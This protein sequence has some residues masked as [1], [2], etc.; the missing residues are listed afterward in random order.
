[1]EERK[2]FWD[3]YNLLVHG[4][5]MLAIILVIGNLPAPAPLTQLGMKMLGVFIGV[6]YGW[7]VA[8]LLWPTLIAMSA[9]AFTG[10]Y[11]ELSQFWVVSFGSET[12]VFL[13]FIFVFTGLLEETGLIKFLANLLISFKFLNN[14]PW[15]FSG[16]FMVA[17]FVCAI[18]NSFA[19]VLIFW[20]IVYI[21]AERFGFRP[22]D[23]WTTLMLMGVI[24]T[25]TLGGLTMPYQPAPL[26]LM[27]TYQ[28][29]TG[30]V[31]NFFQYVV[32]ALPIALSIVILYVL[33]CRFV[34]R[35]DLKGLKHIDVSFVDQD[36]LKLRTVQKIALIF[37]GVFIFFMLAPS[38]LP[39][40]WMF[41]QVLDKLGNSGCTIILLVLLCLI[42]VDGKPVLNFR[43][44]AASSINWEIIFAFAFIIPFASALTSDATGVKA[45][46][47]LILKP[48]LTALPPLGVVLVSLILAAI[49]TNFANNVVIEVIFTTL[50]VSLAPALGIPVVPAIMAVLIAANLS[51]A[52]PVASPIAALMFSNKLWMK[53]ADMYKYG[54][55]TLV[56]LA[57]YAVTVGWLWANIIF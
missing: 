57:A 20:E 24:A 36:A 41:V 2:N 21:L 29:L 38:V 7:T 48:I 53:T 23:K 49:L 32:F 8:G 56:C 45:G 4:A 44:V 26:V 33:V 16:V 27:K 5:I 11:E 39:K 22:Y 18:I 30:E 43:K 51:F 34:Y 19:S 28:A 12:I 15:L 3:N 25:S 37:L 50:M 47:M 9:L 6:L 14:R 1:M 46:I 42:K 17:C 10:M 52:T 40:S 31:I 55:I 35:P 54:V 13:L